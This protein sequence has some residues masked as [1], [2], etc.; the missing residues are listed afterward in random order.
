MARSKRKDDEDASIPANAT[1]APELDRDRVAQRAYELYLSR[2]GADGRDQDDWLIAER[3][4]IGNRGSD[5]S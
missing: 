1:S 4:L 5:E 2:G 3:E